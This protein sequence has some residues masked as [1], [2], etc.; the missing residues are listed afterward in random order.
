MNSQD[1]EV[2]VPHSKD[3]WGKGGSTRRNGKVPHTFGTNT[4][5]CPRQGQKITAYPIYE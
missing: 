5:T 1:K 2:S 3:A 4:P